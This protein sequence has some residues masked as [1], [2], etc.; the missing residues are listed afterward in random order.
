MYNLTNSGF[1]QTIGT[2]EDVPLFLRSV[3]DKEELSIL[4]T[5]V[6]N[7]DGIIKHSYGRDDAHGRRTRTSLWDHPGNDVTGALARCDKV[8]GTMEQV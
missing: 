7:E 3:L 2:S 1:K 4:K 5:A 6:E 8:A